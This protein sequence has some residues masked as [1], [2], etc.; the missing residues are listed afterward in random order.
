[1]S[2][3]RRPIF[4]Y[5]V[6]KKTLDSGP[7]YV[8]LGNHCTQQSAQDSPHSL[9]GNLTD[10]FNWNYDLVAGLWGLEG[11]IYETAAQLARANYGAS[12][13]QHGD[14]LR[15]ITLSTNFWYA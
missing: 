1:M 4:V 12:M 9:G 15:V 11:W 6:F 13:V 10:Q 8:A 7:V 14:D 5:E 3:T 2:C